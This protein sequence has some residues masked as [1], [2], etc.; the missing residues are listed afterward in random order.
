MVGHNDTTQPHVRQERGWGTTTRRSRTYAGRTQPHRIRRA[1][2]AAGEF[3][4]ADGVQRYDDGAVTQL[5]EGSDHR[6][7]ASRCSGTRQQL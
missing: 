5:L 3:R 2:A 4:R 1:D 7:T 6:S